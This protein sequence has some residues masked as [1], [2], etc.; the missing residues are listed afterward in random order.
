M[1]REE[2]KAMLPIMQAF[3]EGKTLQY[4]VNEETN[5]WKDIDNPAF[6]D[7]PSEYRI[8]P[9]PTYRPFKD[10]EERWDEM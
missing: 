10:N 6:N 7:P 1:T 2:I 4:R 8:K 3:A 9:E 5:E